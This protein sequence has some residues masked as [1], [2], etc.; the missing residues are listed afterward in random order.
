MRSDIPEDVQCE[1]QPIPGKGRLKDSPRHEHL[2]ILVLLSL[3]YGYYGFGDSCT[4]F[5]SK[6][7]EFSRT[8]QSLFGVSCEP[9]Y[10]YQRQRV[11]C[12]KPP[13]VVQSVGSDLEMVA[14]FGGDL[15]MDVQQPLFQSSTILKAV[16]ACRFFG[17]HP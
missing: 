7:M 6:P 12:L 17:V 14:P 11:R 15:G 13:L 9:E 3:Y 1:L 5:L 8:L 16:W 10:P 4:R 2:R